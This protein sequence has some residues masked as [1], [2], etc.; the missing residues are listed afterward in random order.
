MSVSSTSASTSLLSPPRIGSG[1]DEHRPQHAVR[2]LARRLVGARAVEAPDRRARRRRRRSWSST[3]AAA[4]ARCRRSRCIQPCS[5]CLRTVRGARVSRAKASVLTLCERRRG[6]GGIP[7]ETGAHGTPAGLRAPHRRGARHPLHPAVVHRRP[8]H[9]EVV[10]HHAGRAGERPRGGHDLRRLGHRRVQPGAGERRARPARSQDVPDPPAHRRRR[11]RWP[12]SSATSS[13]STAP[14]SRAT[15]ATCCAARSRRRARRGFTFYAA[16]ELEYFYFDVRRPDRAAAE[17]LDHGS[18]FELTVADL[19]SDL[20]KKTVLTLEDMGIPVEYSQ[21]E[22]GPSQHE[23]DLRYTDALTMADTV[24][25]VRLIVKEVAQRAR[26]ARDVHAQADRRRA[27]LGHAHPLL[28][29]RGRRQRVPRPGR[30]AQPVQGRARA[31]SPGCCATRREITAVTNQWVNSYKRL[32]VGYEAPVYVSWA[33]NNRSA[34]VRVPVPKKNRADSTRIEYRAPD[35]AC[36]P[37]LTFAVVLAAGLKGI[38]EDYELPPE[39]AANLYELTPA[40]LAGRGH[41]VAARVAGRRARRDGALRARRRRPSA[42]TSSSGS[43]ATSGRSGP[44]TRRRSPSSSST[45]TCPSAVRWNR[46]SSSRTRRRRRWRRRSTSPATRGRRSASADAASAHE[47]DDGWAGA[48]VAASDD[49]DGAFA[50]CRALRKRDL[51]LEPLLLLV[52]GAQL[53]DLELREDLFDDFCRHAVPADRARGAAQAPVLADRPGHPPRAGRVRP[54]GPQ[55]RDLPGRAV[56][57]RPLDLT[58]M[59]Y[60]LLKFLATHPGKVFTRE[61][62]LLAGLGLRV[63]RRRPHGRR[64]RPAPARQARRG[65]RQPDLHR[66]LGR[67]PLR[68]VP[69]GPVARLSAVRR[70]CAGSCSCAQ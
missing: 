41:P 43:S 53:A 24:M 66:P 56:S 23:I 19:A 60:E 16:P 5:S 45:A 70:V 22:D 25:T 7:C 2:R 38:E 58:Y 36:N 6:S 15:P 62:L 4:S 69:L 10:Q 29:V 52:S 35:P 54:A 68:P 37:Y 31:S 63:L 48:V 18:Y 28:A 3:A 61:T 30:R 46:C 11:R 57:G 50:L 21:H 59:E 67:L 8:R 9:P 51:P 64:P 26:R 55:P 13:T 42:S 39:A 17:P 47:P 33:R 1:H 34:L 44:T 20:R 65:A 32:V 12:G 40:E 49:P 27:G 14:R